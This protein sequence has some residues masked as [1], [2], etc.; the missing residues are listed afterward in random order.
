MRVIVFIL[1]VLWPFQFLWGVSPGCAFAA[2][3]C[4]AEL[5]PSAKTDGLEAYAAAGAADVWLP[6]LRRLAADGVD[7]PEVAALFAALG[8][9]PSQDPM[10][11]KMHELYTSKFLR[12][13]PE[14]G[15]P[16]RPRFYKNVITSENVAR[17]REFL[18]VHASA[19]ALAEQRYQVPGEIAAALL[20]VE[21]RL[22]AVLGKEGAFRTL[23]SMASAARPEDIPDWLP[24]LPGYEERLDWMREIM[25]RRAEWAYKE[26]RALLLFGRAQGMDILAVPGS[27]Y[28]AVGIC[29]FMPSNLDMYGADG[30]GDGVVNLFGVPDAVASLSNYLARHGW[31]KNLNRARRHAVLKRYNKADIY[32]DTILALADAIRD[33]GKKSGSQP[34]QPTGRAFQN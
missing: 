3:A 14:S 19:F 21:T 9:V 22:G 17:C 8:P 2:Q 7:G 12:V 27:V 1:G 6:L 15:A 29:Q 34:S 25:P 20:F 28:G 13:P 24:R 33:A 10:G 32:A 23:A 11:R 31:E 16:P 18:R 4:A 30:D 5:S 26:L